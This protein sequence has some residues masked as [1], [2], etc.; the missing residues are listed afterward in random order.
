MNL[1]EFGFG[2]GTPVPRKLGRLRRAKFLCVW[3]CGIAFCFLKEKKKEGKGAT[4]LVVKRC[5]NRYINL[6]KSALELSKIKKNRNR[7][8]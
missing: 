4:S 6:P 3:V 8:S 2:F 1:Q 7:T 5:P